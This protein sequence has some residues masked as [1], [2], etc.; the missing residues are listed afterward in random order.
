MRSI[1]TSA[2]LERRRLLAVR[3][4]SEG[5]SA[6][7]V[8]DFLGVD[9]RTV[10]RWVAAYRRRG[11]QGLAARPV[12]GRPPK[13]SSTQEKIVRRWLADSPTELGFA[14]DLW[15]G[16]RLAQLIAQEWG[17]LFHPD[18]LSTWLRQRGYTPQKPQPVAREHDDEAV[19]WWLARAS[20]I[21]TKPSVG[22]R[23][24]VQG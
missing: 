16:P 8:A 1:G 7:E 23:T 17:I 11:Y 3:R 21:P 15:T 20:V 4:V 12:P 9:P 14:T 19:A 2:E 22:V 24:Q 6:E 13:L 18:S 5:H 10:R